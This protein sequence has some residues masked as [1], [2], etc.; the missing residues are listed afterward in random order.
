M[1]PRRPEVITPTTLPVWSH[2]TAH[3]DAWGHSG[4]AGRSASSKWDPYLSISLYHQRRCRRCNVSLS[5]TSLNLPI[6]SL[7]GCIRWARRADLIRVHWGNM[8]RLRHISFVSSTWFHFLTEFF[9][10]SGHH[11]LK[12]QTFT[13]SQLKNTFRGTIKAMCVNITCQMYGEFKYR[14]SL[15]ANFK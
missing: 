1:R 7:R 6:T 11:L 4:Y 10:T 8:S 15:S 14:S 9:F 5:L 13:W 2:Q 3:T 12:H